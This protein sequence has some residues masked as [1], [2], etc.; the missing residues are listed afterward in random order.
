MS[1]NYHIEQV[2]PGTGVE[3][4]GD[5]LARIL[6]LLRHP[7]GENTQQALGLNCGREARCG[8]L[9][10]RPRARLAVSIL[11]PGLRP[12]FELVQLSIKDR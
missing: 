11:S 12:L 5:P 7:E 8:R 4:V 10:P 9:R 6:N 1:R 3:P 2:K